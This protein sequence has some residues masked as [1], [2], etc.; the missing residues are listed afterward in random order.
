MH[1]FE[2][3]EA[4]MTKFKKD[5]FYNYLKEAPLPLAIERSFECEILSKQEFNPPVLDIGCG[6][7]IFSYVLFDE[8]ID[9][10]IEPNER[11]L[12]RAKEY[13]IY[14]EL[15]KC[16]GDSIPKESGSF[17]TIYSNS[18]L[19]HIPDLL[20]VL[21]EA[22][23]LLSS[24]GKFY[25]TVPTDLFDHYTIIYQFLSFLRLNLIREHYKVFFNK[26]WKH[27]H[28]YSPEKWTILFKKAGFEV[29]DSQ[30]YGSEGICILDDLL[31]PLCILNF[32]IKKVFNSWFLFKEIRVIYISLLFRVFSH[33]LKV[34]PDLE[35]G[36]IIFFT[37][38]K[39]E[40]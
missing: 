1:T 17:N 28:Y 12:K 25:V 37:L 31:V 34:E 19:E 23:R 38:R 4:A 8:K 13:G 11:E 3:F 9:V 40:S 10:G 18:T 35:N 14:K 30:E 2:K 33:L 32:F 20:P 26:F 21:K 6:D 15:I 5:F 39:C 22:H 27:Y 24:Q 7:G 36:G 29:V 16:S